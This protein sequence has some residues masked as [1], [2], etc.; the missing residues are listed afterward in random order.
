M[1]PARPVIALDLP[2]PGIE[3]EQFPVRLPPAMEMPGPVIFQVVFNAVRL[4]LLHSV[5]DPVRVLF[6]PFP[7]LLLRPQ[8]ISAVERLFG[9]FLPLFFS[10][11]PASHSL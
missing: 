6:H 7:V 9:I 4:K 10:H 3:L 8:M 11:C 1:N 2:R 5:G